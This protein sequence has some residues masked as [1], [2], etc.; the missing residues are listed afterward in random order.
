ML[1]TSSAEP[2]AFAPQHAGAQTRL[3][4]LA[5]PWRVCQADARGVGRMLERNL[6]H[7]GIPL[8]TLL[9]RL[10]TLADKSLPYGH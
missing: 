10:G 1:G 6:D 8:A 7:A 3:A 5:L 9:S 4:G 2:L